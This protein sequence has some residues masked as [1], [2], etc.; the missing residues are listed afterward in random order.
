MKE[1]KSTCKICHKSFHFSVGHAPVFLSHGHFCKNW[2]V[3]KI[4]KK[5]LIIIGGIYIDTSLTARPTAD[6]RCHEHLGAAA[7]FK[8]R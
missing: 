1:I 3:L 5:G 6:V 4:K 8:H 2:L 7:R